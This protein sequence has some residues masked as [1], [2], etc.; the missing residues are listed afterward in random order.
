MSESPFSYSESARQKR[1]EPPTPKP[2]DDDNREL[3]YATARKQ[4]E[5]CESIERK[6]LPVQENLEELVQAIVNCYKRKG[7]LLFQG[8]TG[9]GK[10]IYS[11]IAIREALKRLGL[12]DHT[13]MMQPR[14]DA[15]RGVARAT[16]ALQRARLGDE[17]GF[18]TS[19]FKSLNPDTEVKI[20][21]PGIFLRYLIEGKLDKRKVGALIIDE[22]HEGSLEYH[23]CLGLIKKLQAD[24]NAPLILLT[25]ATLNKDQIQSYFGITDEDYIK[26]EGRTYPVEKKYKPEKERLEDDR[27]REL[28]YIEETARKVQTVC[29]ENPKGD[30]LVFM[31]GAKEINQT[32]KQIGE[33]PGVEVVP[34]FG[35]LQAEERDYA[36]SETYPRGITRRI[37]VATNIAETSLT[38][39]NVKIVVDSG[40]QRSTK[41]NPKTGI[42]ESGTEFISQDQA[43]QRAGRA[44]R[45]SDG[46]CYRVYRESDFFALEKHPTPEILRVNLSTLVL[47]LKSLNIEASNF[48]FIVKPSIEAFAMAEWEL[49][50]LGA[51]DEKKELTALGK[52]MMRLPFDAP[53]SRMIIESQKRNCQEAALVIAALDRSKGIFLGPTRKDEENAP[54]YDE[55]TKRIAARRNIQTIQHPFEKGGSDILKSL[56]A[57]GQAVEHGLFEVNAQ[58]DIPRRRKTPEEISLED[59]FYDWCKQFY[60]DPKALLHIAY[61]LHDYARYA[62]MRL[63]Y[64][65]FGEKLLNISEEELSCT[66]LAGHADKLLLLSNSSRG[67]PSYTKLITRVSTSDSINISPGSITFSD[68]PRLC[69]AG[70]FSEGTGSFKNQT[71]TRNYAHN[72]H[73]I[74][75]AQIREVFPN[76]LRSTV[77][78]SWY[79]P[80]TDQIMGTLQYTAGSS[81]A[82][83]GSETLP[84]TGEQAQKAF[85]YALVAEKIDLPFIHDNK[86]LLEKLKQLHH[87]S[88]GKISPPEDLTAWYQERIGTAC[89]KKEVTL[90]ADRLTLYESDFYSPKLLAETDRLYPEKISLAGLE[91]PIEYSFSPESTVYWHPTPQKHQA[92][93]SLD[94]ETV[95]QLTDARLPK[96]G[97]ADAPVTWEIIVPISEWSTKTAHTIAE[98]QA[99]IDNANIEKEWRIWQE[100]PEEKE[101]ALPFGTPFPDTLIAI[102][103]HPL[104]YTTNHAGKTVYSYPCI[105]GR[106][107]YEHTTGKNIPRFYVNYVESE[108][109]ANKQTDRAR[110][111]KKNLD[112]E[113]QQEIE[114]ASLVESTEENLSRA[115]TKFDQLKK[116]SIP[117]YVINSIEHSLAKAAELL[118]STTYRKPTPRY[119]QEYIDAIEQQITDQ[120]ASRNRTEPPIKTA[121]EVSRETALNRW[122]FGFSSTRPEPSI[123]S[124]EPIATPTGI[125]TLADRIKKPEPAKPQPPTPK[126]QPKPKEE[127]PAEMTPA[128]REKMIA[129]LDIAETLIRDVIAVPKPQPPK[130]GVVS[131]DN[132][133]IENTIKTIDSAREANKLLKEIQT[134]TATTTNVLRVQG[135][136]QEITRKA[137]KLAADM[138][139]LKNE[140][141]NWPTVY[142]ELLSTLIPALMREYGIETISPGNLDKIKPKLIALAKNKRPENINEQVEEIFME[143][144][145]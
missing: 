34:L 9:S 127:Q 116:E 6:H 42:T 45:T 29:Q 8:E 39:P 25:S 17:I 37:I 104:P 90:I 131:A 77:S 139:R 73:P 140:N 51:L 76:I 44:G 32:I 137:E 18:S 93:I 63:D 113:R 23:L 96:L 145:T 105:I 72:I 138:A 40:R 82:S 55:K 117:S 14:R 62:D 69:V 122:S 58:M 53:I 111:M 124:F 27:G 54:G 129:S 135:R 108:T 141:E 126:P 15:C 83:L 64:N 21:T 50:Q 144:S 10:S 107:D 134:E 38:L 143:Y 59:S 1:P 48:D 20:V 133:P 103:K 121:P 7:L 43:E 67:I 12:R 46:T 98:A 84:L 5:L 41:F 79:D 2:D 49:Q 26:I 95:W 114:L 81:Y 3:Q 75:L 16:A 102:G 132:K 31:P 68:T 11:P 101:I 47:K 61:R 100:K 86:A 119:A 123:H 65:S 94:A 4:Q 109:E 66:I 19:E 112:D 60:L 99:A 142:R 115:K 125:A 78:A 88:G 52:K 89:T 92:E 13:V 71:I 57:F 74:T 22:L 136:V 36:L 30:V 80:E 106:E 35:G 24:D 110:E 85:L 33:I 118:L 128:V 28:N 87:R 97:T 120:L 91:I 130:K 70:D 56:T